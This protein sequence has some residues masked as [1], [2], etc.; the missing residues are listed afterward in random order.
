M[1]VKSSKIAIELSILKTM[2]TILVILAFLN[3][4]RPRYLVYPGSRSGPVF[5]DTDDGHSYIMTGRSNRVGRCCDGQVFAI[6]NIRGR[7]TNLRRIQHRAGAL[8][9]V[10]NEVGPQRIPRCSCQP[11]QAHAGGHPPP[12]RDAYALVAFRW[13]CVILA[14]TNPNENPEGIIN[15]V[16]QGWPF[17]HS[18]SVD[19]FKVQLREYLVVI[20]QRAL[21]P[22]PEAT[23]AFMRDFGGPVFDLFMQHL[24]AP[25]PYWIP[26]LLNGDAVDARA[27]SPQNP[28]S[29]LPSNAVANRRIPQGEETYLTIDVMFF[30]RGPAPVP[31]FD[32][33]FYGGFLDSGAESEDEETDDDDSGDEEWLPNGEVHVD[34]YPRRTR[35][36]LELDQLVGRNAEDEGFQF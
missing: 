7:A 3:Q 26:A 21:Q 14:I 28:S 2:E 17:V 11:G 12:S 20:Q 30:G 25:M 16:Y 33:D 13:R 23:D 35:L 31:D 9:R 1:S 10:G 34:H 24:R 15:R 18:R 5:L 32:E 8:V 29:P 27:D 4:L 22:N 6:A 19:E 36:A